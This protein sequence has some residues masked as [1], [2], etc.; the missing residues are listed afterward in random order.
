MAN[1]RDNSQL[2][3]SGEHP[4]LEW[5]RE[6]V[7]WQDGE[8]LRF[9]EV[10]PLEDAPGFCVPRH[11]DACFD[12]PAYPVVIR[13]KIAD[14]E[15]VE[16]VLKPR[17]DRRNE[18]IEVDGGSEWLVGTPYLPVGSIPEIPIQRLI[19]DALARA[20]MPAKRPLVSEIANHA[21]EVEALL[22]IRRAARY[23]HHEYAVMR[24][25]YR[26]AL[27]SGITTKHEQREH[28]FDALCV[29]FPEL[30]RRTPS[31]AERKSPDGDSLRPHLTR[32][33]RE[34]DAGD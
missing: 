15:L 33:A 6:D 14:C 28:V 26:E 32:I 30:W 5:P 22:P 24:G 16:A 17:V 21:H 25:A 1:P 4:L 11:F 23:S 9:R 2:V 27:D 10:V 12:E 34:L 18:L 7:E 31:E 19:R 8:G 13:L 3:P 20:A 29:T